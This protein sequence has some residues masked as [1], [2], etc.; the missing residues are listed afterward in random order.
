MFYFYFLPNLDN[1]ISTENIDSKDIRKL[2][3]SSTFS[4]IYTNFYVNLNMF[5]PQ[6]NVS[7]SLKVY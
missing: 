7:R 1:I 5:I 6:I 3:Y 4:N 2:K